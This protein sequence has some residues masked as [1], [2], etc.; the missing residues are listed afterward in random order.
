MDDKQTIRQRMDAFKA[1]IPFLDEHGINETILIQIINEHEPIKREIEVLQKRYDTTDVPIMERPVLE[2]PIASE[3]MKRI[4]QL[5]NNKLNNAFDADVIDTKVGYFLGNPINYVVEKDSPNFEMLTTT[6]DE[7][8]TRESMPLKDTST[9][10]QAS[11]AGYGARLVYWSENNGKQVLRVSNVNPAECIFLY[12]ENMHEPSY[13]IQH[14]STTRIKFDGTKMKVQVAEF[15]D[16]EN[17]WFF[18]SGTSGYELVDVKPHYLLN[19]PLF[20]VENND[21]LQGEASKILALI[22]A[23]DRTMSDANSEVEATRLAILVLRNIGMDEDDIQKLNKAGVFEMWGNDSAD[24]KYLTKD[25]NDTMI[26]HLLDR[27]DKNITRFS[28]SVNFNDEAFGGN[29][30][31]IAMRFKI[32]AL[33]FKTILSEQRF[34]SALTYQF[35]LLCAGWSLLNICNPD[36]YLKIWFGFKRNLP[37]NIKEEAEIQSI[38]QGRVSERTRLSLLSFID[39]VDAEIEAMKQ[40]KAEFQGE[41]EVLKRKR[42]E[43]PDDDDKTAGDE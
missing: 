23:Y 19:P 30:S 9:G 29:I 42:I 25:V 34:R 7:M 22:D 16:N 40:E 32:F 17:T 39:D 31:G 18:E 5:I 12:H 26:E 28:K 38:L 24:I 4:D 14:Y 15:H 8:R 21:A 36:D 41:L 13:A 27:L 3:N 37:S 11:I 10:I 20:G 33:E 1:Y 43:D 35:K 2:L 6:I